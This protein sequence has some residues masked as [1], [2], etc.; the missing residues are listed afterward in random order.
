[1]STLRDVGN[2]ERLAAARSEQP[3][4]STPHPSIPW[5]LFPLALSPTE[6]CMYRA[7]TASCPM[8]FFLRIELKGHLNRAKFE[9]AVLTALERHPLLMAVVNDDDPLDCIW[10]QHPNPELPIEWHEARLGEAMPRL[11][12]IDI[13][14]RVGVRILVYADAPL[15]NAHTIDSAPSKGVSQEGGS[16][17]NDS[18]RADPRG[19]DVVLQFQHTTCDALSAA[20]FTGDIFTAYANLVEPNQSHRF[21]RIEVERLTDRAGC[22]LSTASVASWN[23][24]RNWVLRRLRSFYKRK[25]LS[26]ATHDAALPESTPPNYPECL[27]HTLSVQESRALHREARSKKTTCNSLLLRDLFLTAR[28]WCLTRTNQS[29]GDI[30]LT[31]PLNVRTPSDRTMPASNV[32]SLLCLDRAMSEPS[33]EASALH[34]IAGVIE[35]FRRKHREWLFV[36][37]VESLRKFPTDMVNALRNSRFS[38]TTLLSNIGPALA[39]CHLPKCDGR[40]L[41]GDVSIERFQFL[42]VLRPHQAAAFAVAIYAGAITIGMQ[43]DSR[44]LPAADSQELLDTFVRRLERYHT[45]IRETK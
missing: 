41:A 42:P 32:I 23:R 27:V 12:R 7:D 9:R 31:V 35:K 39:H 1:M 43:Y 4:K 3:T 22:A 11:E 33:D 10:L 29:E 40:I 45:S 6:L 5:D 36:M 28:E 13:R 19:A 20:D 38:G 25:P 15:S 34:Y 21:K 44:L 18:E 16:P 37:S 26:L 17:T 14:E 30:R 24:H 8:Q 2:A